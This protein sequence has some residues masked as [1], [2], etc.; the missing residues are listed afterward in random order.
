MNILDLIKSNVLVLFF[1]LKYNHGWLFFLIG[2]IAGGV[3]MIHVL[4][5]EGLI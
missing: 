1:N 5:E 2:F 4:Q 3:G